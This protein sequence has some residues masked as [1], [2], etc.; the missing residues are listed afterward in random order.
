M[1]SHL[2]WSKGGEAELVELDGDRVR[3]HSTA[4]S[5]PGARVE[6]S[7]RATG[8]AI[9]VKVARCRLRTPT[10]PNGAAPGERTYEL[11]GRLIDATRE[12]RAELARLAGGERTG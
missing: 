9:R 3:L 7:L 4:S 6:G 11:E 5:A 12:V 8:T 1:T 10:E 2:T